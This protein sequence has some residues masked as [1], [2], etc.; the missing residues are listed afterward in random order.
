MEKYLK[1]ISIHIPGFRSLSKNHIII[2]TIYYL[3]CIS[4][5]VVSLILGSVEVRSLQVS[6]S[7]LLCPFIVFALIDRAAKNW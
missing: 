3:L 2:S 5:F 4:I 7:G 1:S 6:V